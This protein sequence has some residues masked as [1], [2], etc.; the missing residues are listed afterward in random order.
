[1]NTNIYNNN[2]YNSI[3]SQEKGYENIYDHGR[4]TSLFLYH[5]EMNGDQS[6]EYVGGVSSFPCLQV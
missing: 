5:M 2:I 4:E 1:M 6:G 3:Q